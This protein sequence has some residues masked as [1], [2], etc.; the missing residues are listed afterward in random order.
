MRFAAMA[1]PSD[2]LTG[3]GEHSRKASMTERW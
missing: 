1:L 2:A 3:N